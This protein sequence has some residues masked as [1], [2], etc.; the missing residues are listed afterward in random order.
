MFKK[1]LSAE[2]S[3]SF[4]GIHDLAWW[5]RGL[6][7]FSASRGRR[8]FD[9]DDA[10][11]TADAGLFGPQAM[12]IV[13]SAGTNPLAPKAPHFPAPPS[14]LQPGYPYMSP[15]DQQKTTYHLEMASP[16]H[17][18]PPQHRNDSLKIVQVKIAC[19]EFNWFLHQAVGVEFRWGGREHWG[20]DEWAAY[21][22]RPELETWVGYVAGTPA[23]YS[24]TPMCHDGK[25]NTNSRP[26]KFVSISRP[27]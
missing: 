2:V 11:R 14:P 27:G 20:L 10:D 12:V 9:R 1:L 7:S 8:W 26:E 19:P 18:Q 21:V 6:G 4:A 5:A 17:L 22:E 13:E 24:A 16:D 15:A 3:A 23:G 25:S